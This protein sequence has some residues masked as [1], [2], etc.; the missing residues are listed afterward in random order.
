MERLTFIDTAKLLGIFLVIL[1]HSALG[2]HPLN[3]FIFSFHMPLFFILFGFVYKYKEMKWTAFLEKQTKRILIPY[4]L[5]A[6]IMASSFNL[7]SLLYICYGSWQSLGKIG[8]SPFWFLTCYFV[9]TL[10]VHLIEAKASEIQNNVWKLFYYGLTLSFLL[11]LALVFN[12]D[13]TFKLGFPFCLNIACMGII[14]CYIGRL[15][16]YVFDYFKIK[17]IKGVWVFEMGMALI[18]SGYFIHL[19]NDEALGNVIFHYVVMAGAL[20]GNVLSFLL[21]AVLSSCGLL[22]FA[23]SIDNRLFFTLGKYTLFIFGVHGLTGEVAGMMQRHISYIRDYGLVADSLLFSLL[24]LSVAC[25][26]IPVVKKYIPNLIG[27]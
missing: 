9:M 7:N 21:A 25:C 5:L 3:Q 8:I 20:Y 13:N 24:S 17:Q 22:L 4:F 14:F 11:V 12:Y 26:A 19:F 15:L 23:M 18:I 16:R 6:A 10:M 1:C 2:H 27:K